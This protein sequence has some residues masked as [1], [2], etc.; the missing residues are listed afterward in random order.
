MAE[1]IKTKD[2]EI[3]S[4]FFNYFELNDLNNYESIYLINDI[5]YNKIINKLKLDNIVILGKDIIDENPIYLNLQ[6]LNKS[7]IIYLKEELDILKDDNIKSFITSFKGIIICNIK[8]LN[9]LK[10]LNLIKENLTLKDNFYLKIDKY[11]IKS[12]IKS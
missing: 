7:K 5:D 11:G 10:E 3:N 4:E 6:I 2:N 9:Y 1:F 12:E 8:L